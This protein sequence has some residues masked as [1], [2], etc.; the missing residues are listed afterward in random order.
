MKRRNPDSTRDVYQIYVKRGT[1]YHKV[2]QR[3]YT[4]KIIASSVVKKLNKKDPELKCF[5]VVTKGLTKFSK[6]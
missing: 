4:S 3:D 6:R 2:Y 1:I 5:I